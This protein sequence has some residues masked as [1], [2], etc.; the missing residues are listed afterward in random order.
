MPTNVGQDLSCSAIVYFA[1]REV[2]TNVQA[3]N[4]ENPQVFMQPSLD[5][6]GAIVYRVGKLVGVGLEALDAEAL[7][8]EDVVVIDLRLNYG[9]S[10]VHFSEWLYRFTEGRYKGP[11]GVKVELMTSTS[12][13][14]RLDHLRRHGLDAIATQVEGLALSESGWSE[15]AYAPSVGITPNKVKV[16]V[17]TG[18]TVSAVEVFLSLLLHLDNVVVLGTN[19][20]GATLMGY[21]LRHALPNTQLAMTF[22]ADFMPAPDLTNR[23][24]IG[25]L[26]DF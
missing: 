21:N 14:L 11:G 5:A 7:K 16:I 15:I 10:S 6:N 18:A 23:E 12:K 13:Q 20:E 1:E 2:R 25:Y 8:D 24:G 4:G 3:I 22:G 9:G 17:L 19:T 26:P